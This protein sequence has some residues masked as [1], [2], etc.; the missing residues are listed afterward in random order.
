MLLLLAWMLW[1]YR[2]PDENA[3]DSVE[4][5]AEEKSIHTE[6]QRQ[7]DDGNQ[8]G[9]L[10]FYKNINKYNFSAS[11]VSKHFYDQLLTFF[12]I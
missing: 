1:L 12:C 4:E 10:V 11:N 8:Q 7:I 5:E 6:L 2:Y 3:R 9:M